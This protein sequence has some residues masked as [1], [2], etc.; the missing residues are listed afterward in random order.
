MNSYQ[1]RLILVIDAQKAFCDVCGSLAKS[2]GAKELEMISTRLE[3]LELALSNYP[4][5][6]DVFLIRSEY[7]PGQF[8]EG[9]LNHPYAYA[10]V[11]GAEDDCDWSLSSSAIKG[12]RVITKTQ[13]SA[14]SSP[15][16]IE[17]LRSV[18]SAGL[19][20]ILIAGF[21][22]TSCVRKTALD[23]RKSLPETVTVTVIEGLCGSRA[24]NYKASHCG[25]ISRHALTLREMVAAG[26]NVIYGNTIPIEI[27]RS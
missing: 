18:A 5:Q 26:V 16:F 25:G 11:L 23:I 15:G 20:E 3:A 12:K 21:L 19:G 17:E 22:M 1:E 6:Q 4:N 10:C 2:F 14:A 9:N 8:S 24:S 13:E 27:L 7:Q